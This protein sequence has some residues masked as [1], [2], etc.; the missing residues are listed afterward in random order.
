MKIYR[1]L[2]RQDLFF[3][4][5]KSQAILFCACTLI[6]ISALDTSIQGF[7]FCS[8]LFAI[9][10]RLDSFAKQTIC[11]RYPRVLVTLLKA[12]CD[13]GTCPIIIGEVG[14]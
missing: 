2:D 13:P 3:I 8:L 7:V 4:F 6:W 9:L 14:G 11:Q 1:H 10:S 12:N 5:E